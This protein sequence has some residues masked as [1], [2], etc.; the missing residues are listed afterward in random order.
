MKICGIDQS[1]TGSGITIYDE[2]NFYYYLIETERTKETCAPDIDN[3][4]RIIY[5]SKEIEKLI[6]KHK[7]NYIAIEGL[8]FGA[9]GRSVMTMGGLSHLLRAKFVELGVNFIIIPPTTLKKYWFGKGNAKKEEMLQATIDRGYDIPILK[10]YGTKKLPDMRMNDN[11][12]DS[13]ALCVF[14]KELQ[15][16]NITDEY[17]K[18]IEQSKD[19]FTR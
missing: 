18:N 13:T 12:V 19:V 9:L 4:R 10:N 17:I 11:V 2:N 3:T 6:N 16:G 5:I 8:A 7:I 1:L 15:A 14:A